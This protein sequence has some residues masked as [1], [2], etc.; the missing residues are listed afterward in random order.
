LYCCK[1]QKVGGEDEN[2]ASGG[3]K[4]GTTKIQNSIHT[5]INVSCVKTGNP[6]GLWR[7]TFNGLINRDNDFFCMTQ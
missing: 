6:V 7:L 3:K 4:Y 5:A 2:H 1:Q